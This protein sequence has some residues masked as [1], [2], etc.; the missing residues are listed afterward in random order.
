MVLGGAQVSSNAHQAKTHADAV[1]VAVDAGSS[2]PGPCYLGAG[3]SFTSRE[4]VKRDLEEGYV[5]PDG[6][7]RDYG[8]KG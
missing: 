7:K 4:A 5:T 1:V 2:D 3:A 6:V 8:L